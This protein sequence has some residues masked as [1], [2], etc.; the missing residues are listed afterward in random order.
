[1]Q[2]LPVPSLDSNH[3]RK[4]LR[5]LVQSVLS[6][7]SGA[8]VAVEGAAQPLTIDQLIV[9]DQRWQ[10]VASGSFAAQAEAIGLRRESW[11]MNTDL[12][13]GFSPRLGLRL[14]ARG[15]GGR[16]IAGGAENDESVSNMTFGASWQLI[17]ESALPA[18]IVEYDR[19][20][21][22]DAKASE[23]ASQ[24]VAVTAYKTLDPI[25]L[26]T[27]ISVIDAQLRSD[28]ATASQ[29]LWAVSIDTT[30]NFAVNPWVTLI[31][32]LRLTETRYES[33]QPT[34]DGDRSVS[35]RGGL[36]T[37]LGPRDSLFI[38]GGSGSRGDV[39]LRMSWLRN[40]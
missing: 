1:M 28:E 32:G 23:R 3:R 29:D 25:V 8:L 14:G 6:I 26:S 27:T 20:L 11:Q 17:S 12:R 22:I 34:L 38:E 37:A 21:P 10:F 30:A 5:R 7:S 19:S 18:L 4:S 24:Q 36:A 15:A 13:F 16:L 2:F 35:F 39:S 40:F 33:V 31:A 9:D